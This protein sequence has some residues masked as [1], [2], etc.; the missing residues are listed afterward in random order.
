VFVQPSIAT[1]N[2]LLSQSGWACQRLIRYSGKTVRFNIAPFSLSGTL[3]DDGTLREAAPDQSADASC[4]IPISLL[5]RLILQDSDA[6]NQIES[7][8]DV[9]LLTEIFFLFHNLRWDAAEDLSHFTGDIAAERV[10]QFA[11]AKHQLLQNTVLNLSQAMAEYWTEEKPL[12]PKPL[13]LAKFSQEVNLLRE[14]ADQ[15]EQRLN[16]LSPPL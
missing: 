4:N 16:Q 11:K 15:L 3:Q 8:G 10:V 1:L 9:E 6:F 13:Q 12:L 7:F 14:K 2:H 5:P